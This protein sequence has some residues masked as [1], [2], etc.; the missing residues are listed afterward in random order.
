[1][2]FTKKHQR[3][4]YLFI[5]VFLLLIEIIIA[6]YVHDHI[7]R[8]YVGDIIVCVLICAFLRGIFLHKIRFLPL[9]VF[10]FA[11]A[12]E[13]GQ[14]FDIVSLLGLDNIPVMKTIIG[15]TFSVP[16]VVCYAIGCLIF[17]TAEKIITKRTP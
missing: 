16:D 1:M 14:Y 10:L 8:P 11:A 3:C 15:S 6:L 5:F 2:N 13:V 17:Y 7:V 4:L 12:V 9:Y